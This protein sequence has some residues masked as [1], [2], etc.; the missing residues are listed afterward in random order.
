MSEKEYI[1][2][3][4]RTPEELTEDE[5][6]AVRQEIRAIEKGKIILDGILARKPFTPTL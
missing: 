6:K 2:S 1:E 4:G 5:L 3:F